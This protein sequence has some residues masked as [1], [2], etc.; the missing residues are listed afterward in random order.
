[1][2]SRGLGLF[3]TIANALRI[4]TLAEELFIKGKTFSGRDYFTVAASSQVY[5]IFQPS[6]EVNQVIFE[7]LKFVGALGGPVFIDIYNYSDT[8]GALGDPLLVGNRREGMPFP[9]STFHF[10][11]AGSLNLGAL[12]SKLN[13]RLLPSLSTPGQRSD[14]GESAGALPFAVDN[15]SIKIIKIDNSDISQAAIVEYNFTFSE[16]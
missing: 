1:M 11:P 14:S 9:E 13:G 8:V 7:P 4:N 10:I 16:N 6:N 5:I 15:E 3:K 2:I 12:T